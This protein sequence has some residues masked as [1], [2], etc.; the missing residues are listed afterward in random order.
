M[1]VSAHE[2][3]NVVTEIT[4]EFSS[5]ERDALFESGGAG[6]EETQDVS[7]GLDGALETREVIWVLEEFLCAVK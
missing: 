5:S 4:F 7:P 6:I 3:E 2:L 1:R